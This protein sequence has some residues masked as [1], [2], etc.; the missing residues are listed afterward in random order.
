MIEFLGIILLL[1]LFWFCRKDRKTDN[2]NAAQTVVYSAM[3]C[4]TCGDEAR[5]YGDTWECGFC[6]D[7]GRLTRK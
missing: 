1:L 4:P 3:R 6:G 7:C 5:I 2:A